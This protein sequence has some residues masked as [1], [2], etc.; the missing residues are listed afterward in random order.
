MK[1]IDFV[2]LVKKELVELKLAFKNNDKELYRYINNKIL[3][4][5]K[6]HGLYAKAYDIASG[7]WKSEIAVDSLKT[8][9][10]KF[11]VSF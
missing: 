2:K 10:T 3:D 11:R 7:S 4:I 8:G 6:K 9:K 1:K 5:A